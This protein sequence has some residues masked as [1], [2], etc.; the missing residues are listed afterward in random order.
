MFDTAL[1]ADTVS[2]ICLLTL[3]LNKRFHWHLRNG[4]GEKIRE[5]VRKE[6]KALEPKPNM[7]SRIKLLKKVWDHKRVRV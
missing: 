1:K 3:E 6:I 2:F 7:V 5:S 4:W